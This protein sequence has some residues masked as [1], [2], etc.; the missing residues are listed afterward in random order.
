MVR[1]RLHLFLASFLILFLELAC[2]RWFGS[3][4]IFLTFFTNLVLMACFLGMTLGCLAASGRQNLVQTTLPLLFLSMLLACAALYTY[5]ATTKVTVD[6]GRQ[7]APQQI[8]F[9]TEYRA[10]NPWQVV[11]PI[12]VIGAAFFVFV[13]LIFTGPGQVMG[14]AFSQTPGRLQAYS[15]NIG[16]SL[17]GILT[18]ALIA[19]LEL[20][21]LTWFSISVVL[22]LFFSASGSQR[23]F[24]ILC[25]GGVLVLAIVT[26][27]GI[28]T[29]GETRWS[30]YY[31]V[32]YQPETGDI[33]VNNIAHQ[34]MLAIGESGSAYALPHLLN[35]DSGNS[36]FHDVLII[37]AGSG[38]DVQSALASGAQRVDAVEIDPVIYKLG[39]AAHPNRPYSDPRVHIYVDDGRSFLRKTN[40]KYDLIVYAL[41]DSLVLHSGFSSL[42]LESFLFTRQAFEEVRQRLKPG[43]IFAMY[44]YYRQGWV[45]ARLAKLSEEVFSGK[46]VVMSMPYQESIRPADSQ[47]DH[48]TF[49]IVGNVRSIDAAFKAR[50]F[51]WIHDIPKN[52]LGV[53]AFGA[54][55]PAIGGGDSSR[56][57]KIG[58]SSVHTEEISLMP[59]DDWPFLYLKDRAIPGLN[60]RGML[61]VAVLSG[62]LLFFYAPDRTLSFNGQMFFL[63]AGFLLLE[64][65]SVVH[66][67]L[68]FGATWMVNSIVIFAILVMILLANLTVA[69]LRPRNTGP[70]YALLLVSLL[71]GALIP[72][73]IFLSLPGMV[74]IVASCLVVFVPIF[75]AGVIFVLRFRDSLH[76]DRDFGANIAGAILG[77]LCEYFSVVTGFRYL[78]L[79]AMLFYLLSAFF[80]PRQ[81]RAGTVARAC[82]EGG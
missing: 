14:R 31:K 26:G 46:P 34:T 66:M 69:A 70:Y 41:V 80:N 48:I 23:W 12:E 56:W 9:G 7:T 52:N 44:N 11:I 68:L 82:V 47:K 51:F 81:A 76:P 2:I 40:Q 30:P 24:Q 49:L 21:P 1:P 54:D 15:L 28:G 19:F 33:D 64:T 36:P 38:N 65:K 16:G 20:T 25:A 57:R 63:G 8:Y 29:R 4:V 55:P 5:N 18:F 61:L 22:M 75:F 58:P 71:A 3:T 37:G 13:A 50:S 35:R 72:M 74:K 42:R 39:A 6:V 73:E 17:L 77:G 45:V 32:I 43:G 59:S 53:N 10:I 60:I 78:L 27:W 79:I 62:L 67:A